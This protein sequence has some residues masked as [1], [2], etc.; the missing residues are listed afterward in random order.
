MLGT[1]FDKG[2][3]GF[4]RT[5][6]G[7]RV[8]RLIAARTRAHSAV[9]LDYAC[10]YPKLFEGV[11]AQLSE[12][13]FEPPEGDPL[14]VALLD[15]DDDAPV[16]G[17]DVKLLRDVTSSAIA[18]DRQSEL[19][20]SR[21]RIA[22]L[23]QRNEK[24]ARSTFEAPSTSPSPKVGGLPDVRF[25]LLCLCGFLLLGATTAIS[26]TWLCPSDSPSSFLLVPDSYNCSGLLPNFLNHTERLT[27]QIFRPNTRAFSSPASLC[28]IVRHSVIRHREAGD[29]NIFG[30]RREFHTESSLPVS[31]EECKQMARHHRCSHGTLE[32]RNGLWRTS[33]KLSFDFPSAPFGCC[34]DH[35]L[36]VT[37]CY[38]VNISV[39]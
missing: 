37:N 12:P 19:E 2:T 5:G 3:E 33:H 34:V 26:D 29:V 17:K 4:L 7:E 13:K 8:Y 20:Q 36:T 15:M 23:L 6:Y 14:D 32:E 39:L 16:Q 11:T 25:L 31:A 27:V 38:L 28:R 35:S 22:A 10:C 18:Q 1:F 9:V 24:L 21:S 30:A